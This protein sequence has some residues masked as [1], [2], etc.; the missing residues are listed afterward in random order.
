[1]VATPAGA[2]PRRCRCSNRYIHT[3]SHSNRGHQLCSPFPEPQNQPFL[4]APFSA[5][6]NSPAALLDLQCIHQTNLKWG[7]KAYLPH[8][9]SVCRRPRRQGTQK[10]EQLKNPK[11]LSPTGQPVSRNELQQG[12]LPQS[13]QHRRFGIS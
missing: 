7:A 2:L 3:H 10:L 6:S 13:Y 8:V 1:M 9:W 12:E 4:L 11:N 5:V